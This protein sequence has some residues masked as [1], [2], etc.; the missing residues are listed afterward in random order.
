MKNFTLLFCLISGALIQTSTFA[1]STQEEENLKAKQIEGY[2]YLIKNSPNENEVKKAIS[3]LLELGVKNEE[4][5]TISDKPKES[6]I[7]EQI[8]MYNTLTP[9]EYD[10]WKATQNSKTEIN[11]NKN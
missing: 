6:A 9:E 11:S 2:I 5:N 3:Y 8:R 10:K 1:Q 4:L 7:D